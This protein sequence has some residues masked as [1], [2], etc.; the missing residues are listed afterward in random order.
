[1]A[2]K[3]PDRLAQAEATRIAAEA[4]VNNIGARQ[5][6]LIHRGEAVNT[7]LAALQGQRSD[8]LA[9]AARGEKTTEAVASLRASILAKQHEAAEVAEMHEF[10]RAEY[11]DAEGEL[12]AARAA[13]NRARGDALLERADDI[14]RAL[15]ACGAQYAQHWAELDALYEQVNRLSG[16]VPDDLQAA[17]GEIL[18][19]P[20]TFGR[21]GGKVITLP[22]VGQRRYL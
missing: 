18:T 5:S 2:I 3:A 20:L 12:E 8:L 11:L 22:T 4:R 19:Q 17:A 15:N 6:E 9:R 1:M 13:E 7:D 14:R 16:H 21:T 10:L